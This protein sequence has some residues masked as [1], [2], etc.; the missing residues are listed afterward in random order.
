MQ[1]NLDFF[2]EKNELDLAKDDLLLLGLQPET[3]K[4]NLGTLKTSSLP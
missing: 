1:I 4:R 3:E 2:E